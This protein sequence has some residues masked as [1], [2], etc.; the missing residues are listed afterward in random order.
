MSVKLE[1][2][3]QEREEAMQQIREQE[4]K[5]NEAKA[6]VRRDLCFTGRALILRCFGKQHFISSV[7]VSLNSLF[8]V[9]DRYSRHSIDI[10]DT[11]SILPTLDRYSRHSIDIPDTRSILPVL[12]RYSRHSIDTPDTPDTRSIFPT[13]DRYSRHS[14]H[15][16]DIPDTQIHE[17]PPSPPES[18]CL[19]LAS[20]MLC[21]LRFFYFFFFVRMLCVSLLRAFRFVLRFVW[22]VGNV[23]SPFSCVL[24]FVF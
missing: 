20:A 18:R 8:Q 10:P 3:S 21:I 11:R 22:K 5:L 23:C 14:R 24:C 13:L 1:R 12:D 19:V 7:P 4:A 17:A 16:I 9:D 15:S 2:E 6:K